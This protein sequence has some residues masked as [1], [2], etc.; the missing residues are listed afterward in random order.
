MSCRYIV[1]DVETPNSFNDR[2]SAIGVAVAE[3]GRIKEEFYTL[4]NPETHFDP[5]NIELTGITPEM[6]EGAPNFAELWTKIEPMMDGGL[7]VA[8]NAP[9]DMSVLAKCLN[10]Y[11]L[12][13]RHY[14]YYACTCQMSKKILVDA[15]NHKLN[16]LSEYLNIPLDH[17]NAGSDSR[18]C[19]E[20]LLYCLAHGADRD[21]FLRSYDLKQIRTTRA[22]CIEASLAERKLTELQKKL[23]NIV[24][25]GGASGH[26]AEGL[27]DWMEEN[28]FLRGSV[29]FDKLFFAAEQALY[30]GGLEPEEGREIKKLFV[31]ETG[32]AG[33]RCEEHT[34]LTGKNCVLTGEFAYG[35]RGRVQARLAGMG[36]VV[37]NNVTRRTDF[38]IVGG[39]G[40]GAWTVGACGSKVKRALEMSAKGHHIRVLKES[41]IG[42]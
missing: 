29:P 21:A 1:F 42:F 14:A 34:P 19:A 15:P 38:V 39:Y 25:G 33:G 5:F 9:F 40:S 10:A 16:T 30:S 3:D 37:Q 22:R 11:G 18:A 7:L 28:S 6:T 35:D 32:A 17:H 13:W 20:I 31:R 26:E 24:N 8:H 41:E 12:E 23:K 36:A 27:R 4:V 2:M